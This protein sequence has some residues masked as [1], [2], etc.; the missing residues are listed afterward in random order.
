MR[1]TRSGDGNSSPAGFDKA[2][3]GQN[4]WLS[5]GMGLS[6]QLAAQ[7]ARD[8]SGQEGVDLCFGKQRAQ[9]SGPFP[10]S[11]GLG[12]YQ[13]LLADQKPVRQPARGPLKS[14]SQ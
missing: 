3:P 7:L 11:S 8:C 5:P 6:R 4:P 14:H 10:G 1:E 2:L 9:G 13:S 12:L